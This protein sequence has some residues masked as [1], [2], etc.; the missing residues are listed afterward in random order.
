MFH[1]RFQSLLSLLENTPT[2]ILSRT[3]CDCLLRVVNFCTLIG[4]YND[5][6]MVL[7]EQPFTSTSSSSSSSS[8]MSAAAA[9]LAASASS[10][11]RMVVQPCLQL[12]CWDASIGM[13]PLFDIFKN[14]IITSGT[15]SPLDIYPKLLGFR[16]KVMKSICT[17]P[18][19]RLL[20]VIVTRGNDHVWKLENRIYTIIINSYFCYWFLVFTPSRWWQCMELKKSKRKKERKMLK[21]SPASFHYEVITS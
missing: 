12:V 13:K 3:T 19:L 17:D 21:S 15:L 6:F 7:V 20:P 16:P 11:S 10:S 14:V 5:G 9:V 8:T 4:L 18:N 2:P 1:A